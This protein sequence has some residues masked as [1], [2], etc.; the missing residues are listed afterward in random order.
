MRRG[1]FPFLLTGILAAALVAG[2]LCLYQVQLR[3]GPEAAV[4]GYFT[5]LAEGKVEEAR[6]FLSGNALTLFQRTIATRPAAD[7]GQLRL[8]IRFSAVG[9][10]AA[11]AEVTAES[12]EPTGQPLGHTRVYLARTVDGWRIRLLEGTDIVA[13]DGL[14]GDAGALQVA[15]TY[16]KSVLGV[17]ANTRPDLK[18]E[19]LRYNVVQRIADTV[20]VEV[21]YQLSS[22][23]AAYPVNLLLEIRQD[24]GTWRIAKISGL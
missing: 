15:D 10:D 23:D 22:A 5:A 11:V 6:A 7:L 9:R 3:Q 17:L 4:R 21:G 2:G 18:A 13:A 8:K 20:W 12:V 24:A 1:F 16:V 14:S 19:G